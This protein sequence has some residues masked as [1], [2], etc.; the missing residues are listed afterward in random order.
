MSPNAWCRWI[1]GSVGIV[2]MLRIECAL[3][4]I[5][6]STVALTAETTAVYNERTGL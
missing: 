1:L 3:A 4:Q 2:G 6:T 5:A